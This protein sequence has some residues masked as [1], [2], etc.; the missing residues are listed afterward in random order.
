[1]SYNVD[2]VKYISGKLSIS[3]EDVVNL[4]SLYDNLA[5]SNFLEEIYNTPNPPEDGEIESP[6]WNGS[7]SG[8]NFD[9]FVKRV[10]PR[11]RGR[12]DLVIIWEGGDDVT[13]LRVEDGKVTEKK[14][15]MILED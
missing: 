10:L 7:G 13:G 3:Y 5:E 1:M 14:V 2:S 4:L 9:V 6:R 11:T 8:R 12:A 15:R